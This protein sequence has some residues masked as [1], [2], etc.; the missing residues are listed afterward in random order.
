[1]RQSEA[2]TMPPDLH[3]KEKGYLQLVLATY[4]TLIP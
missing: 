3:L 2:L 1:M 4:S